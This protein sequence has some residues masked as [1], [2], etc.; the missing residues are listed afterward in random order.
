MRC[1]NLNLGKALLTLGPSALLRVFSS[2]FKVQGSA[3]GKDRWP[4][5][6]GFDSARPA[7]RRGLP[8]AGYPAPLSCTVVLE[9]TD[10]LD[11]FCAEKII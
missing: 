11:V 5:E 4:N 3:C 1:R 9:F 6:V 2:E 7:S 8:L 10:A